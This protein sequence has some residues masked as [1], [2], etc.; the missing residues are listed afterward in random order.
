M[1]YYLKKC[2][3]KVKAK[4]EL[5]KRTYTRDQLEYNIITH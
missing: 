4:Y 2:N 5:L 1:S 3:K